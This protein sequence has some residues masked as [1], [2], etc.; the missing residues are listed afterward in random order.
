V[1]ARDGK[2]LLVHVPVSFTAAALGAD[3]PVP[4][5]DGETV[6]LRLR[7]GTQP[8][9]RHRVKGRGI[10]TDKSVGDLIV[11]VDVVVPTSL[12]DQQREALLAFAKEEA[13]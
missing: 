8:G 1:F 10:T 7:A 12:T 4:T 2:N 3:V 6:M 13:S 11:T 9:S 5:L